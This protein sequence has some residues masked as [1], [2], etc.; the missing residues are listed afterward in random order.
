MRSGVDLDDLI[1]S[2]GNITFL[3]L[4]NIDHNANP[5]LYSKSS[6]TVDDNYEPPCHEDPETTGEE[7]EKHPLPIPGPSCPSPIHLMT[8][9][10]EQLS[11]KQSSESMNY[12]LD[13]YLG[14]IIE[15]MFQDGMTPESQ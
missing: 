8:P 7:E 14:T 4:R 3:N 9:E 13:R 5:H 12:E 2:E 10:L 1:F 15:E 6:V 11:T